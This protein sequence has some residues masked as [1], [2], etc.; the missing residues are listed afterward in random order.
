VTLTA[1]QRTHA[2]DRLWEAER[3]QQPIAP[4]SESFAGLDV[5]DAYEIQLANI[6]RRIDAGAVVRG[7]KVGLSAK[8]MQDML[9]V[10]EPDYGHLLDDMFVPEGDRVPA[11]R[12]CVPRV[13]VEVAFVLGDALPAPGCSVADVLRATAFVMPAIEIIDSRIR[14][15]R[16]TLPDTIADNASSAGIVLGGR[17]TSLLAVDVR[18][19]GAVLRR[20]GEIVETGA[21]GAVLGNPA[22]AV[23][24]LANKVHTFGVTLEAGHVILPGSCTR[25]V[26]VEPGDVIRADFDALGHV[27][28][29]FS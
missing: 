23:A 27:S 25:A 2:A 28:V 17:R 21:A 7:H 15:W 24:W 20:N 3:H 29:T 18:T 16:I 26:D 8:A 1:A 12:L 6:R 4:L 11:G 9:G 13:E 19:V 14:D 10:S 5:A 22:T